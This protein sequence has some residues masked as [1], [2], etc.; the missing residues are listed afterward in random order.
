M[1]AV[2]PSPSLLPS[3]WQINHTNAAARLT[4]PQQQDVDE[5]EAEQ[6]MACYASG[7]GEEREKD[8]CVAK[9][10]DEW[11]EARLF[12]LVLWDD[13]NDDEVEEREG[14][15]ASRF[16]R[17][18]KVSEYQFSGSDTDPRHQ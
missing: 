4:R 6:S 2:S 9:Y 14:V 15:I 5:M 3:C 16:F 17:K 8:P 12:Q 11:K 7:A 1:Y 18:C 13:K 10:A